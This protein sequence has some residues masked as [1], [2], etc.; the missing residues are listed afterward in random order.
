MDEVVTGFLSDLDRDF[1]NVFGAP[2]MTGSP[3]RRL[4]LAILERAILDYVGNDPR[5]IQEAEEWLFNSH[6]SGVKGQFSF[7]WLCEQLDLDHKRIAKK[8]RAMPRRGNR[9]IAPWYFAKEAVASA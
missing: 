9:K 1:Y 7:I 8:I 3:E 2:N 5:E 4:L 6:D